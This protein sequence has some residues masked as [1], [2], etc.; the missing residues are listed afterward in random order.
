MVVVDRR[1][2]EETILMEV[3]H[4]VIQSIL[5]VQAFRFSRFLSRGV[6]HLDP[7]GMTVIQTVEMILT[8]MT[9]N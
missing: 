2:G 8:M 7:R 3:V 9:M 1:E 4:Q 5:G 6:D